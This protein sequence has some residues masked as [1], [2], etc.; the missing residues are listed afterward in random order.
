MYNFVV[1]FN[2]HS[3]EYRRFVASASENM[4]DTGYFSIQVISKA[5]QHQDLE[6]IPFDSSDNFASACRADPTTTR[7]YIFNMADHWFCVRQFFVGPDRTA[8][9]LGS[10]LSSSAAKPGQVAW[11][12]LN[13]TL[14][15]P[16]YMSSFYITEY[17]SQMKGEN[18]SIFVVKGTLPGCQADR[19]LPYMRPMTEA[20]RVAKRKS[21]VDLTQSSDDD[22]IQNAIRMNLK[23]NGLDPN[24][25]SGTGRKL[26]DAPSSDNNVHTL[27]G[28]QDAELE[29]AMNLS[30]ECFIKPDTANPPERTNVPQMTPAEMRDKRLQYFDKFKW[31]RTCRPRLIVINTLR[32]NGEVLRNILIEWR[33]ILR[34]ELII[35]CAFN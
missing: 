32:T 27:R 13:S 2:P 5:L 31:Y 33:S 23:A 28:D 18:Y 3:A 17:L 22:E 10:S 8:P 19:Q 11:F 1:H 6:L 12:N 30:M 16:Q 20:E 4:D 34:W 21:V 14:K 15:A 26:A 7:A 35:I 25:F 24:T 29:A 9:T